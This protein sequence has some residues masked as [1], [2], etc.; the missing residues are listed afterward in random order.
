MACAF[1]MHSGGEQCGC[2]AMMKMS[3]NKSIIDTAIVALNFS[4]LSFFPMPLRLSISA[5]YHILLA[6][7]HTH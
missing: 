1:L 7:S 2:Q 4:I 6:H 5:N 3:K